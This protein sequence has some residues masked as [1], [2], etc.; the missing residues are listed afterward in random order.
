MGDRGPLPVFILP[1]H[2]HTLVRSRQTVLCAYVRRCRMIRRGFDGFDVA[3]SC[4]SAIVYP[5]KEVI[6]DSSPNLLLEFIPKTG[7]PRRPA[8]SWAVAGSLFALSACGILSGLTEQQ[9]AG[10]VTWS[11]PRAHFGSLDDFSPVGSEAA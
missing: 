2:P 8:K 7:D 11:L 5:A 1:N 6:L 4:L 10:Q 3:D 9:R